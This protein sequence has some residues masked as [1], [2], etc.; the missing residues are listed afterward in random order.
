MSTYFALDK[1]TN[2]LIFPVGGGVSRVVDGRFVVQQVRSKLKAWLGEWALDPTIGW[3]NQED[4]IKNYDLYDIE[5][6]AKSIILATQGVES[7]I[8]IAATYANRKLDIT[9]RAQTIY[10][11]INL[12]VPWGVS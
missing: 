9:F 6:R 3:L 11:E 2:D 4:F 8:E 10:G 5:D 1:N 12:T 7:I